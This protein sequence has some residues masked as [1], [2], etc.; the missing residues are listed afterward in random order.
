MNGFKEDVPFILF[1]SQE[2]L[3]TPISEL[4]RFGLALR[5]INS[6]ERYH[7]VLTISDL[8]NKS[9]ETLKSTGV[10]KY[11]VSDFAIAELRKSLKRF[12]EIDINVS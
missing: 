6:L 9:A 11:K 3:E 7:N 2:Q 4:E 5:I 1:F 10:G 12:L 8:V